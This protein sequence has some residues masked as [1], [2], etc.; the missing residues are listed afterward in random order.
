[1]T[2][3]LSSS[4]QISA[5]ERPIRLGRCLV[6]SGVRALTRCHIISIEGALHAPFESR[7]KQRVHAV[8]LR[9]AQQV[10]LD[11]S[12]LT[13]IDAAGVGELVAAFNATKAAG[14]VLEIAHVRRRVRQVLE[15]TGVYPLLAVPS[16]ST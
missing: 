8:L 13:S 6:D 11:L 14:G 15:A 9:G 5:P 10:R 7:L 4:Q 3:M 1:M 16:C 12:R 2:A